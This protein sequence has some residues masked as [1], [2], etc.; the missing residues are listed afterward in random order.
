LTLQKYTDNLP[1][2][3]QF[4]L[5]IRL[6]KLALPI[7]DNYAN[8]NALTYRDTVVGLIHSVDRH[9]LSN[10]IDT[11]E[12]HLHLNKSDNKLS[13]IRRQYDDPV[14]ALQ[15]TD[16]E[17]PDEVQATFY[18][19]YNLLDACLGKVRTTFEE[20]T[21]YVSIN[22]AADALMKSKMMTVDEINNILDDIQNGS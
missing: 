14:V 16:W 11:V 2:D 7:W 4:D 17:L 6:T 12:E 3:K 19:V 22:Q 15:D 21:I 1:K 18:S 20:L 5:A 13:N 10:T 9:L 8:K